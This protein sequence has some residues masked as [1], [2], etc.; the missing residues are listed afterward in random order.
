MSY[1]E[2]LFSLKGKIAI[3]T[4]AAR[5]NGRAIAKALLRA[6]A[7]GILVDKLEDELRK[8]TTVFK[9]ERL[10]AH[11]YAL[12]ITNSGLLKQFVDS[13]KNKYGRVD[14]LV[15]NAGV[16]FSHALL[17]YPDDAWNRTYEVNL[18]APYELSKAIGIIMKKQR[19][20]SIINI[21]SLNA[22]L[23]FPD[24]PAYMAFKGA[25]RQL[26]KSIALDLG[27]YG[28]RANNVGP[29][30]F[31]TE[32]T[33]QSWADPVKNK[34]RVERTVLGRW[35]QPEDLAGIIIFLA[36]DASS[37]M[38]GQDIYVDGGWLIKGL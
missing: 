10:D 24:N 33:K 21:T 38:T 13:V 19:A 31:R 4:G 6:G 18:K 16:T 27:K 1:L 17:D 30:Y 36:S 23:A 32:M 2:S 11:A 28:V 9:S 5:G 29:G 12:D 15:N 14:I 7:D 22:E 20:G 25:L 8:I 3:V 26:T 34:Q 35:G 37:Y